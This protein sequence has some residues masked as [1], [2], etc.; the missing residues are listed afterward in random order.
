MTPESD[1]DS[2]YATPSSW[3]STS[4]D[5]LEMPQS[6]MAKVNRSQLQ[7]TFL[8]MCLPSSAKTTSIL[9]SIVDG[10]RQTS[11]LY[12]TYDLAITDDLLSDA[13]HALTLAHFGRNEIGSVSVIDSRAA[14]GKAMRGLSKRL[15]QPERAF[16]DSTLAAAMTLVSYE[17]SLSIS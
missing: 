4:H 9:P 12:Q 8:Y 2:G 10:A 3:S 13:L 7:G 11:W 17:V 6:A 14:Y 1:V 5:I 15:S 16:E